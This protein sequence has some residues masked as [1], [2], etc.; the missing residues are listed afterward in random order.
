MTVERHNS[1][2]EAESFLRETEGNGYASQTF[3]VLRSV[4]RSFWRC[5]PYKVLRHPC[6]AVSCV[7]GLIH[8]FRVY[9]AHDARGVVL[10]A[11]LHRDESGA[12][13]VVSDEI[14]ELDYVDFLYAERSSSE[15]KEAFQAVM[16]R[17][18]EDGIAN[19]TWRY[20]ET[21]GITADLLQN[22]PHQM[23]QVTQNVRI[24][25]KDGADA[26]A[27]SLGRN[28]RGNIRETRNRLRRDGRKVSFVFY[29][30]VGIGG[31]M[32]APEAATLLRKC[33]TVYIAR[34]ASRYNHSGWTARLF[35]RHGSYIALSVPGNCS[36]VAALEI[37]GIVGAYMEGYVN[38]KRKALEVP[39]IAIN[40][41]FKRYGPGRL[42]VL[43]TA[44]W[45][46]AHSSVRTIDLC[47]G[48][49]RYKLELGGTLY[50]TLTVCAKTEELP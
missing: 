19:V 30:T 11:P 32:L 39:R 4:E 20:L 7:L 29:S 22:W 50:T 42:L 9:S 17:M 6:F 46:E 40:D 45:L 44:Q 48:G 27:R 1:I 43:E 14:V 38:L 25:F 34:Q 28:T 10:C 5:L 13:T 37:D 15:R 23:T 36:F 18:A 47:R 33:R 21:D 12:W 24:D 41:T 16:R 31:D 3:G 8:P 35:F 49:E 2:R 26:L